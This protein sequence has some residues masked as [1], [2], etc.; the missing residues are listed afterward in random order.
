MDTC[1]VNMNSRMFECKNPKGTRFAISMSTK[2]KKNIKY[3]HN[4]ISAPGHQVI[5]F[6][7]WVK[8]AMVYLQNEYYGKAR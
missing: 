4:H 2:D 3:L 5:D 1:L 6:F 7:T 8:K